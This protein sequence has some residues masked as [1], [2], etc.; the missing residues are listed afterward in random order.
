MLNFDLAVTFLLIFARI[1]SFIVV[2]PIF[3]GS[4]APA[5]TKI[6]VA[7]A[8]SMVLLP[9]VAVP[10][11]LT[12][13]ASWFALAVAR[14]VFVGLLTGFIVNMILQ[15]FNI[16]GQIFDLHIGFLM[17]SFFDPSSG[18]QTTLIAKFLYLMGIVLFFTMD[19]HHMLIMG[20]AKSFEIVPLDTALFNMASSGLTI[21]RSFARMFTVAVQ[22][23]APVIAVVLIIDVCLGLLGRTAPQMN[24]LMLGFP[25]KI[26]AGILTLTVMI[27]LMGTVFQYLFR[28]MEQDL[29]ILLKGLVGGG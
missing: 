13:S 29:Y 7:F 26:A 22:I 1:G 10:D 6:G 23:S 24:I 20:M 15:T 16:L 25:V 2:A 3:G 4:N 5:L 8:F 27:P 28:M 11:L 18:G 12:G 17:S 19:G 21:I 9:V 14:E